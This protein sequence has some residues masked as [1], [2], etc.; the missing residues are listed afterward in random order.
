[1]NTAPA[2][3]PHGRAARPSPG[4]LGPRR[5]SPRLLSPR[6]PGPRHPRERYLG[7]RRP[8]P[9]R[10]REHPAVR[11]LGATSETTAADDGRAI[12]EVVFLG[13]LVL[14]PVIYILIAVLR[15][16]SATLAVSQAARDVGRLIETHG[17]ASQVESVART[18]LRDQ[19]LAADRMTVRA[20][21]PGADCA[22]DAEAGFNLQPGATYDVCVIAT[23]TLPGVPTILSGSN[24]TVTGVY[25]VHIGGLR[26]GP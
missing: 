8:A 14:I 1:M 19:G 25:T 24:N 23:V 26:E 6:R 11:R 22:T 7:Q 12:I 20:V 21:A 17:D 4:R 18:D 3:A 9:G 15:L 13:V 16:Q 5:L 10:D 2:R